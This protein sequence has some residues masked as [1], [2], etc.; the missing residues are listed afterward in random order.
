MPPMADELPI[1]LFAAAAEFF[2]ELDSANRYA[3]VHRL[4][5]A[6]RSETRERRLR[7]FVAMVER[8]EKI[9]P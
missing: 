7:K 5:D 4:G 3:I 2:A 1:L 6:K 9:R 8:G